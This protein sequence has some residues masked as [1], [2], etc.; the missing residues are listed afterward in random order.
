MVLTNLCPHRTS[1]WSLNWVRTAAFSGGPGSI[2]SRW[3]FPTP[4][5]G[6]SHTAALH[7]TAVG[8]YTSQ[9]FKSHFP[10]HCSLLGV[11]IWTL[12]VF[13]ATCFG[14]SISVLKIRLP[15]EVFQV[16]TPGETLGFEFSPDYGSLLW[17]M[18]R[19]CLSLAYL[20]SVLF[21]SLFV[22]FL[23]SWSLS[24]KELSQ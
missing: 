1:N 12:L 13:R 23:L 20:L 4:G 7:W 16:F 9:L 18:V 6:D 22:F 8:W 24:L 10:G 21:A 19:L 17:F 14:G 5:L 2:V 15:G 3:A 11:D